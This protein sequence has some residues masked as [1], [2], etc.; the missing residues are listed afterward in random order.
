MY[1]PKCGKENR[2]GAKF[3]Y[4]CGFNLQGINLNDDKDSE[5]Q[6]QNIDDETARQD[7][8]NNDENES[9]SEEKENAVNLEAMSPLE[10]DV[11][12]NAGWINDP[13]DSLNGKT[14]EEVL[15]IAIQSPD[16]AHGALRAGETARKIL[17]QDDTGSLSEA[18]IAMIY[19][20]M[21][22]ARKNLSPEEF[23]DVHML[24]RYYMSQTDL[25][26]YGRMELLHKIENM[27]A[28]FDALAPV[29]K[30][31]GNYS[32][33]MYGFVEHVR[34]THNEKN[35]TPHKGFTNI[36][37]P[38]SSSTVSESAS[39]H[40]SGKKKKRKPVLIGLTIVIVVLILYVYALDNHFT[41]KFTTFTLN[42]PSDTQYYENDPSYLSYFCDDTYIMYYQYSPL[43]MDSII[44]SDALDM[45]D[46]NG[47]TITTRSNRQDYTIDEH[48][49]V[50]YDSVLN[51]SSTEEHGRIYIVECW[52]GHQNVILWIYKNPVVSTDG[53][54]AVEENSHEFTDEIIQSIKFKN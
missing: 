44:D 45:L 30:Y 41:A 52:G 20:N 54:P 22:D 16:M 37:I 49:I 43:T 10:H 2:A 29:E 3:C 7:P 53:Y 14:D 26:T 47:N 42:L 46:E 12:E 13:Y 34:D 6:K 19:V 18:Q 38:S 50:Q 1:C 5:E 28:H 36:N 4:N 11:L 25:H 33:E 32:D 8:A 24:F 9:I 40:S 31:S 35:L 17:R 27:F 51:D 21:T 15:K 23:K 48:R 39:V